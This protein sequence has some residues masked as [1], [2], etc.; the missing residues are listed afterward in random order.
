MNVLIIAP[1]D[2][3]TA[4]NLRKELLNTGLRPEN[5]VIETGQFV[6]EEVPK[7]VNKRGVGRI[8]TVGVPDGSLNNMMKKILNGP[9]HPKVFCFK[10]SE[11]PKSLKLKSGVVYIVN[12]VSQLFR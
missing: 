4:S 1:S 9:V 6:A 5:I 7:M 11:Q 12:C 3:P 8:L 2:Q 10:E